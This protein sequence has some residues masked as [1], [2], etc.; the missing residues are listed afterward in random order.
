MVCKV[1]D[2]IRAY[3]PP[4]I[5]YYILKN[6]YIGIAVVIISLSLNCFFY[7][8]GMMEVPINV[9]ANSIIMLNY[10]IVYYLIGSYAAIHCKTMVENNI[11]KKRV[12]ATVLGIVLLGLIVTLILCSLGSPAISHFIRLLLAIDIW[13]LFSW[14][15]KI[16]A[17][18]WMKNS[19]FIY[20]SHLLILQP[21][22]RV[23]DIFISKMSIPS[24]YISEYVVLP[25]LTVA[26]II[27]VAELL[28]KYVPMIASLLMGNRG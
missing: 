3:L 20:C 17:K 25:I 22:Q 23:L 27:V 13:F 7:I 28:K 18:K 10:Q 16:H 26:L 15:P 19:F 1:S 4:H 21:V 6:K 12:T 11:K 5:L 24:L 2:D 8:T 9:N 14:L